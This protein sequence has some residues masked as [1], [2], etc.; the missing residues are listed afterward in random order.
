MLSGLGV[1]LIIIIAVCVAASAVCGRVLARLRKV[2][3]CDARIET[4]LDNGGS[5]VEL[6]LE[7]QNREG[8][9]AEFA[10]FVSRQPWNAAARML[11]IR[12]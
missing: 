7:T 5:E 2:E 6:A 3:A 1:A 4:L 9:A 10:E 8:F 12:V 11:G